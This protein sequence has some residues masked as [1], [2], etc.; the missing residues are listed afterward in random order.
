MFRLA[1]A[2]DVILSRRIAN[3]PTLFP[4][5]QILDQC[6]LR[7]ANLEM[8][9]LQRMG[10]SSGTQSGG[11]LYTTPKV[12]NDL[13]QLGINMV[14]MANN[15]SLDWG[16]EGARATRDFLDQLDM[17]HAGY[18]ENLAE[19][20]SPRFFEQ[21]STR[22]GLVAAT[23]T[24]SEEQRAGPQRSDVPGRPGINAV[25]HKITCKVS[26]QDYETLK[27]LGE[28]LNIGQATADNRLFYSGIEYMSSNTY[29]I[30]TCL[31]EADTIRI[32]DAIELSAMQADLTILSL[33]T[34]E[35]PFADWEAPPEFVQSLCRQAVE[36]GATLVACH[37]THTV[38]GIE[39]YQGH[40]IFYGLGNFMFNDLVLVQPAE[41]YHEFNLGMESGPLALVKAIKN[42]NE[43]EEAVFW[44]GLLATVM[45]DDGVLSVELYGLALDKDHVAQHGLP[46][47]SHGN[48]RQSILGRVARL[49]EQWDTTV[50]IPPD[51]PAILTMS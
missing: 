4:L 27:R 51:G 1:L 18:G 37:G 6:D 7:F 40:P 17:V 50:M 42:A 47:L 16:Y 24:F 12:L 43:F 32:L 20:C 13:N 38:R 11:W 19:A 8:P 23:T 14:S 3:I 36:R 41:R 9:I 10:W 30:A 28:I 26:Q 49:S 33:H 46:R 25:S 15:H 34:H 22:V 5:Q 29:D 35:I 21:G 44:E 39:V 31:N 2:G 48:Q 45:V